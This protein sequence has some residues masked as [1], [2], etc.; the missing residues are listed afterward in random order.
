[1]GAGVA[2]ELVDHIAIAA[3]EQH[4]GQ[5][6]LE[7]PAPRDR[8]EVRLA[9]AARDLDQVAAGEPHRL[10]EHRRSDRNRIIMRQAP[11][12]PGRRVIDER[13][14]GGQ[15]LP[16]PLLDPDH[17]ELEHILEQ[18]DLIF[19]VALGAGEEELGDAPHRLGAALRRTAMG[20]A[21]KFDNEGF[22]CLWLCHHAPQLNQA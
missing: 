1:M 16:R 10:T 11:N 17:Q 12:E 18:Q 2:C 9:L 19:A 4:V 15:L 3:V 6:F 5:R 14:P 8:Q 21:L 7:M 22:A 13:Q 20:R